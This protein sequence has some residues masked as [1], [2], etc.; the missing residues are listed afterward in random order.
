MSLLRGRG[1]GKKRAIGSVDL[2]TAP[3]PPPPPAAASSARGDD[4]LWIDKY[5]P[6]TSKDLAIHK[7]KVDEV[8]EWLQRAD[9]ALQLGLPP[10]PRLLVLTGPAGS[11]KS[12]VLRVLADELGFETCEWV[13][14]RAASRW[15]DE[16]EREL[17]GGGGG[18]GGWGSSSDDRRPPSAG[19]LRLL[20]L[21]PRLAPYALPLAPTGDGGAFIG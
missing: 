7:K 18:D 3:P 20:R 5:A 11:G 8:R 14:P 19:R 12:A 21:S 9:T 17:G 13:E 1:G 2:P 16:D 15:Q 4:R 10:T 6:Q